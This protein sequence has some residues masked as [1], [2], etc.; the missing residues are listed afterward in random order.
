[1]KKI[2]LAIDSYKGCLSSKE[3]ETCVKQSLHARFPDSRIVCFPVADGG[4]GLLEALAEVSDV[5]MVCTEVHDPLM[6]LRKACYELLPDG[7]TAVVEMAQASGLPLLKD[8]ERNLMRASTFGTGELIADALRRGCRK[9]LV[10]IGGSATNDAGMGMLEALGVRFYDEEG[11]ELPSGGESMCRI[12]R[13]DIG[14]MDMRL[15]GAEF[16]VACDVDNPF[17]GDKGA[18]RIFGPQKGGAPEQIDA[19]DDGMRRFAKLAKAVVHKDIVSLPGAGAAGGLGGA[20]YAFLNA[21]LMPGIDLMLDAGHFDDVLS[22]A[23]CVITGEGRSDIQTLMGKVPS[24]ILKRTLP[25]GIPTIL[26]SGRI[27]NEDALRKAGFAE[28]VEV[29]PR[30]MPLAEAMLPETAK[31]N[32]RQAVMRLAFP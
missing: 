30:Q 32:I 25:R 19:L 15:A 20:L 5:R 21:R 14:G 26:L 6:R 7:E 28:L 23:D 2:I 3:V 12:A 1:M 11:R 9:F 4:E 16:K 10:G 27:E 18:A 31:A 17:C 8:S 29:S 22:D 24:G 13:I